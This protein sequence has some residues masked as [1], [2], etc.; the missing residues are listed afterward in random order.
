MEYFYVHKT[1]VKNAG[2]HFPLL[3]KMKYAGLCF[4]LP[5]LSAFSRNKLLGDDG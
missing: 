1:C 5:K 4:V 2:K 3:C